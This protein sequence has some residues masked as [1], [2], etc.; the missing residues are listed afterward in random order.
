MNKPDIAGI[1]NLHVDIDV[2]KQDNDLSL[3]QRKTV[4][5]ERLEQAEHPPTF[6]I[7]T[8][9][10][11][12]AVW[13]LAEPVPAAPENIAWAE[14]ANRW[15]VEAFGG[16]HLT[17]DISRLL[18]LPGTINHP[19]E[20]KRSRGR[21]TAPT[22][23]LSATGELHGREAFGQVARAEGQRHGCRRYRVPAVDRG[24]Q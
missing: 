13:K 7:D 16:D 18:R 1:E 17:T 10:G 11:L 19:D 24:G 5:R 15:L 6:I 3:D 20:R 8:G 4:A 9:G 2:D 12:Q 22:R 23:L 21:V 14:G